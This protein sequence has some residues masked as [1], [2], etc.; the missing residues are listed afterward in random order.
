[1]AKEW[2]HRRA[3]R[4]VALPDRTPRG[5]RWRT[6]AAWAPPRDRVLLRAVRCAPSRTT[7]HHSVQRGALVASEPLTACPV[8]L[9]PGRPSPPM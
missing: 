8:R 6:A 4:A 7:V 3:Q 2:G 9:D 5:R 1:L